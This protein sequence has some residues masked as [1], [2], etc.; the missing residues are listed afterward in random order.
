MRNYRLIDKE[1][2]IIFNPISF[3][4]LVEWNW[5]L[6]WEYY[7]NTSFDEK[8]EM[9][10][11]PH[12]DYLWDLW[13]WSNYIWQESIWL[14]DNDW[15]ELFCWDIVQYSVYYDFDEAF[16]IWKIIYRKDKYL[17]QTPK[18]SISIYWN[19]FIESK[20]PNSPKKFKIIWNIEINPELL[21]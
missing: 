7:E 11:L 18:K 16:S 1:S 12:K 21:W 2:K 3:Q 9:A 8:W 13:P 19:K 15:I 20:I 17:I 10:T 6:D 14:F 4:E 5:E